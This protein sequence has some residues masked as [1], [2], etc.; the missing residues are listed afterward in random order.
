[1]AFEPKHIL[2]PVAVEAEGDMGLAEQ[3]VFAACDLAA[4]FS[5]KITLLHL[6]S[7]SGPGSSASIDFSGQVYQ[8]FM[9][10]LKARVKDGKRM[11]KEL[12]KTAQERGIEVETRVMESLDSTAKVILEAACDL[13]ADLL[14]VGSHGH[15]GLSLALF[16]SVSEKIARGASIPVLMLHSQ[17]LKK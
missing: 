7:S 5:S 17:G 11:L 13:D 12:E 2:V 4:K 10:L 14:V 3:A 15:S 16:G 6:V 9:A 8:S 1:M